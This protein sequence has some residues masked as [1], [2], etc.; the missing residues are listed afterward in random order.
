MMAGNWS[1]SDVV[2]MITCSSHNFTWVLNQLVLKL[3]PRLPKV[4]CSW[5]LAKY[6]LHLPHVDGDIHLSIHLK[7]RQEKIK[8]N[9][10]QS[11]IH[12]WINFCE[13]GR[14]GTRFTTL[15]IFYSYRNQKIKKKYWKKPDGKTPYL[16][17]SKDKNC[18][19]PETMQ[20]EEWTEIFKVLRGKNYQP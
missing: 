6:Y 7:R 15:L 5:F 2:G 3:C 9:K 18:P 19:S 17:R 12:F 11:V 8:K 16:Q 4:S 14:S 10:K 13:G 20:A 1:T